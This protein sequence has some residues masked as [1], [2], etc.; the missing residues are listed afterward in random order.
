M[1][2][3]YTIRFNLRRNVDHGWRHAE[4]LVE[5]ETTDTQISISSASPAIVVQRSVESGIGMFGEFG[6]TD[7]GSKLV[8]A[9]IDAYVIH[10]DVSMT[11]VEMYRGTPGVPFVVCDDLPSAI[12]PNKLDNSGMVVDERWTSAEF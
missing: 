8:Q 2:R 4:H 3:E 6:M 5:I 10:E 12:G 9:Y 7:D 1:K 11:S